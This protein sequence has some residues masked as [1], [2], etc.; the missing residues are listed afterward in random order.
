MGIAAPSTG[1]ASPLS[2]KN[3]RISRS[4]PS[5]SSSTGRKYLQRTPTRHYLEI[6]LSR[7]RLLLQQT[8]LSV[9]DVALACGFVSASHFSKCYREFFG[10]KPREERMT[11]VPLRF[12]KAEPAA[13]SGD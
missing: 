12:G 5:C 13:A 6:R 3:F 2:E 4:P 7:A 1:R 10:K 8:D 9:L 11:S